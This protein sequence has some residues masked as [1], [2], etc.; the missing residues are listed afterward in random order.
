VAN[1]T[2]FEIHIQRAGAWKIDS[3]FDDHD[4]VMMEAKRMAQSHR[5]D[6]VRV[7]EETYDEASNTSATHTIFRSTKEQTGAKA[8]TGARKPRS[9][10]ELA[11]IRRRA[12]PRKK[13]VV[14]QILARTLLLAIIVGVSLGVIYVVNS[15]F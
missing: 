12:L 6:G 13:T 5:I 10:E 8:Q 3:I 1:L 11:E 4:L 15:F 2:T 9:E 7:V 14:E